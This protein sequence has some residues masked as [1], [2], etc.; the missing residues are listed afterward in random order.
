MMTSDSV[1]LLAMAWL[2]AWAVSA[3]AGETKPESDF[4]VCLVDGTE[5]ASDKHV[6]VAGVRL[7]ACSDECR[8]KILEKRGYARLI[9]HS[10]REPE[11]IP[12]KR[13]REWTDDEMLEG[14]VLIK[15]GELAR[16]GSFFVRRGRS[17]EPAEHEG[18]KM[19]ISSFYMDVHEVTYE[20]YCRFLN[21]GNEG[22]ATG[23]VTRD[24]DGRFVPSRPERAKFPI[25][26]I[27]YY[28]ARGYAEWAGKRLPTE[29]EWEYAHSGAGLRTY[30]WG[31]DEPGE[32]RANFGPMFKGLKPV[33]SLPAGRTP[34]GVFDLAGNI[35]E[36]CADY[37]DEEYY[38]KP[39]GE[40]PYKDPLGPETGFRRVYRLGCQ[41]KG[42]TATDLRGNLRCNASP[43]RAAGCVGFRCV[44]S[45]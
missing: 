27:N 31:D 24:E 30:P 19:R 3:P 29:A 22:Y 16:P 45:E 8:A 17:P 41:C 20:D 13:S 5:V 25:G 14:M 1:M 40:N 35:G 36:W 39:P 10:G 44:K 21:D 6:D 2:S 42:A 4:R 28:Q 12:I 32:K 33:G 43:L 18:Y 11:R 26:G 38:R 23:G 37:Y 9:E 34:E 7:Y 15:G